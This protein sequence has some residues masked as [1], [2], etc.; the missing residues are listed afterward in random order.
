MNRIARAIGIA[1]GAGAVLTGA[2]FAGQSVFASSD[3]GADSPAA[4]AFR[5]DHPIVRNLVHVDATVTYLDG[6][7]RRLSEAQP[8]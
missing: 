3:S 6:S 7:S 8:A 1:L 5:R 2:V 4:A